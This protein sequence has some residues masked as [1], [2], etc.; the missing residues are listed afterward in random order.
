MPKYVDGFLLAVPRENLGAYRKLA[1]LAA[2][3][4][5]EHGALDYIEA[6]EDEPAMHGLMPFTKRVK[7]KEG[8]VIL[9]SFIVY[10]S[11]SDRN[12]VN[13]AVMADPRMKDPGKMP[14]DLKRMSAGGF[15]ALVEG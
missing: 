4:W 8:E 10:R 11:K 1:K 12:R 7:P 3:V 15:K 14:F 5:K 9:F 2:R 13:K 6:V